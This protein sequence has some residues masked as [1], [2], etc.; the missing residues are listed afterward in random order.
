MNNLRI[1]RPPDGWPP[2]EILALRRWPFLSSSPT[3]RTYGD[4]LHSL[5]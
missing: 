3:Y 2:H 5:I 4:E 1:E